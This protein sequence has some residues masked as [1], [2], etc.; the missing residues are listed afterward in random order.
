MTNLRVFLDKI[1]P[2]QWI[3]IGTGLVL[4]TIGSILGVTDNPPGIISL[5]VA[6]ICLAGAW[7]WNLPAPRDYWTILLISLGA[8]PI[9]VVLHN[10]FYA[11]AILAEGI[12][13][14]AELLEIFQVFFFLVA[15]MAVGPAGLVGLIGGIVRSWGSMNRL[16]FINRS[17]R[18]FKEK[19]K[20]K[21]K[22]L[23]KL[24]NLARQSASGANLQPLKYIISASFSTVR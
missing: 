14:I 10:G 15:V 2:P 16:T 6:L 18:R 5:Y 8:F 13:V 3:L 19:F 24:I 20:I 12:P 1:N 9:G 4:G 22:T 21:E 23:L 17:I 7:V 11:L